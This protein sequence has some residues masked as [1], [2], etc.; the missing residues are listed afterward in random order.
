MEISTLECPNLN[1][2]RLNGNT[3]RQIDFA[4]QK[5]FEGYSVNLEDHYTLI[6]NSVHI[7]KTTSEILL[8]RLINRV[9][10][11][12]PRYEIKYLSVK[13]NNK[14]YRQVNLKLK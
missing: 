7:Q 4:I 12:Y 8:E 6:D 2:K 14:F 10:Y 3:T 1:T 13:N 9:N 5:L 11:E